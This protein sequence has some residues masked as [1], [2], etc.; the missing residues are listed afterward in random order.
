MLT[1]RKPQVRNSDADGERKSGQEKR[2][3]NAGKRQALAPLAKQIKD[4]ELV[5]ARLQKLI[6]ELDA[7]LATPGL[8]EKQPARG[9]ELAKERAAIQRKLAV[10]EE[11]WLKL[12]ESY[13]TAIA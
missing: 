9:A 2:K 13:E 11:Q 1:G 10:A 4:A 12:S 6:G 8:F 7:K 3:E 5:L